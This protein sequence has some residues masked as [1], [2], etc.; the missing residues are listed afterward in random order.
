[1]GGR[2]WNLSLSN[3]HGT[4]KVLVCQSNG[5]PQDSSPGIDVDRYWEMLFDDPTPM[6]YEF[7]PGGHFGITR[8]HARLRTR[9]FYGRVCKILLE[10]DAAPWNIERLECYIFNPSIQ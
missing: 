6:N 4:G 2:M 8:D 7:M 9:D 1:M 10:E 3:H 5:Q